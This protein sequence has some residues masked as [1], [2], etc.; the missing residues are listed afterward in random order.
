LDDDDDNG[1]IKNVTI[2]ESMSNFGVCEDEIEMKV[3]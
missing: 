3:H 2:F 1:L